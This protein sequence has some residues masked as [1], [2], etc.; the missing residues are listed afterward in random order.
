ME[1][2]YK[3]QRSKPVGFAPTETR[4]GFK[5]CRFQMILPYLKGK[6]PLQFMLRAA[7]PSRLN[8]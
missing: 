4:R 5:K 3:A 7:I 8:S 6:S 1:A 2:V